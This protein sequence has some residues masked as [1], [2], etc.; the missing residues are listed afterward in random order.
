MIG[1]YSLLVVGNEE[2]PG[3]QQRDQ[4]ACLVISL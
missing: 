1:F 3:N 2:D 4:S